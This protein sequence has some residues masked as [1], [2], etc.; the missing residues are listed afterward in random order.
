MLTC[1][2]CQEE[3]D[4]Q[5][6]PESGVP[7]NNQFMGTC[8]ICGQYNRRQGLKDMATCPECGLDIR[9]EDVWA[10]DSPCCIHYCDGKTTVEKV[11]PDC[12]AR[13]KNE[14]K[15]VTQ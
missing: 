5:K 10:T 8:P 1:Q 6:Y 15:E 14:I 11:C 3:I 13:V 2:H 7:E 9:L 12:G 4:L